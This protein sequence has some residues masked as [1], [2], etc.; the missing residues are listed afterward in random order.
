MIAVSASSVSRNATTKTLSRRCVMAY[1]PDPFKAAAVR[2]FVNNNFR[3]PEYEVAETYD[4]E[5]EAQMFRIRRGGGVA[6]LFAVSREFL[7]DH[8]VAQIELRL[9]ERVVEFI[10]GRGPDRISLLTN[11]GT[12]EMQR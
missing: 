2:G 9:D 10:K 7:D 11:G 4:G 8:S 6:H 3:A 5:R 1:Q 12:Q